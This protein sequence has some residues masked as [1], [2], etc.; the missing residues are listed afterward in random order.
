MLLSVF[1]ILKIIFT[2]RKFDSPSK[3]HIVVIL[4]MSESKDK[5][6]N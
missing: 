4:G 1:Q 2:S 6:L 5:S 3:W